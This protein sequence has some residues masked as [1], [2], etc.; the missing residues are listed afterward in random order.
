MVGIKNIKT[1][2][3]DLL[4]KT[5]FEV[6]KDGTGK[7]LKQHEGD[8]V[9][10]PADTNEEP[11][12]LDK[13]MDNVVKISQAV[14]DAI[15][16]ILE[17]AK[18]VIDKVT[19]FVSKVIAAVKNVIAK[20]METIAKILEIPMKF[21]KAIIST[22]VGYVKKMLGAIGGWL[23]DKLNLKGLGSLGDGFKKF[24]NKIFAVAAIAGAIVGKI[25]SL[26]ELKRVFDKLLGRNDIN[27]N[28]VLSG[29]RFG[30]LNKKGLPGYYYS[31]YYSRLGNR[32]A[33]SLLYG[34]S[35][36][37]HK[38]LRDANF[39]KSTLAQMLAY[40]NSNGLKNSSPRDLYYLAGAK[41]IGKFLRNAYQGY[42]GNTN[43]LGYSDFAG[44]GS[45]LSE[46]ERIGI[47]HNYRNGK[48]NVWYAGDVGSAIANYLYLRKL[49]GLVS[50]RKFTGD[51]TSAGSVFK[52]PTGWRNL[53]KVATTLQLDKESNI[54]KY[55]EGDSLTK[56]E[57]F[58]NEK[59]LPSY[60]P[61]VKPSEYSQS[62]IRI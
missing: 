19:E 29:I 39:T 7:P 30:M 49:K 50:A 52:T 23:K 12:I 27:R 18:N 56:F 57:G 13:I 2:V 32:S 54:R 37:G 6:L 3:L 47:F 62:F 4:K 43:Y 10:Y 22:V 9:D 42:D 5:N 15:D 53:N 41:G 16:K 33:D 21:I 8:F 20:V 46:L 14:A 48:D 61:R 35:R 44:R 24:L 38:S 55:Q 45:R 60:T 59:T 1:E 58:S 28:S 11:T 25:L 31:E 51:L 36:L 40:F 26:K 17:V 34:S